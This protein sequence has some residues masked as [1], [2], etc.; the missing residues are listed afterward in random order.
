MVAFPDPCDVLI[1]LLKELEA[2]STPSKPFLTDGLH[3]DLPQV[4]K[5]IIDMSE[6]V[7]TDLKGSPKYPNIDKLKKAGFKVYP[8][9]TDPFGWVTG[10]IETKKGKL[11]L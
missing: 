9:E 8:G 1:D 2:S 6:T 4:V 10:I 5:D 11:V 7:L 3:K